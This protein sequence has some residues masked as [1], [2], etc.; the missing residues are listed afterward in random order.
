MSAMG[1]TEGMG[2]FGGFGGAAGSGVGGTRPRLTTPSAATPL[3]SSYPTAP[4]PSFPGPPT[5]TLFPSQQPSLNPT[6]TPQHQ[7]S[8][9][10][11]PPATH[12]PAMSMPRPTSTPSYTNA[13]GGGGGGYLY[14]VGVGQQGLI[15]PGL[16]PTP[17]AM[18]SGAGTLGLGGLQQ[19]QQQQQQQMQIIAPAGGA[20]GTGGMA[21][22]APGG[23]AVC[24]IDGDEGNHRGMTG[25]SSWEGRLCNEACAIRVMKRLGCVAVRS[26]ICKAY[27][28]V[29][30]PNPFVLVQFAATSMTFAYGRM[31][32][33]LTP[34]WYQTH[35]LCL[36]SL[37]EQRVIQDQGKA[38]VGEV[39]RCAMRV[40][41]FTL[42]LLLL[43]RKRGLQGRFVEPNS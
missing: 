23:C 7:P 27:H 10:A 16:M 36:E 43:A 25:E 8:L 40:V 18:P 13:L 32:E 2:Q 12:Q 19:Q 38:K 30:S 33:L 6:L 9:S 34:C 29:P 4:T 14:G 1:A 3:Q 20:G 11:R 21:V 24:N 17:Y 31:K 42:L 39:N 5:P 26:R 35:F 28:G 37:F 41:C 15:T 22:G